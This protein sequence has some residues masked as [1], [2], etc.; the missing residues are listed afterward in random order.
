MPVTQVYAEQG[1]IKPEAAFTLEQSE[2]M[3]EEFIRK[4]APLVIDKKKE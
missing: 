1:L 3:L 2:K 4:L